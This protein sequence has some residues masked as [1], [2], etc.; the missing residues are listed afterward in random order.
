MG[1]VVYLGPMEWLSRYVTKFAFK[2]V[3]ALG[4][5]LSCGLAKIAPIFDD[6]NYKA[7]AVLYM[8][9]FGLCYYAWDYAK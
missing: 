7:D 5:V 8:L 2:E 4:F 3:L 6:G 9:L 1:L